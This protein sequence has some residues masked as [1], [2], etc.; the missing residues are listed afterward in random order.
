MKPG[1]NQNKR[2]LWQD[3]TPA[4]ATDKPNK[5]NRR[6]ITFVLPLLPK[7]RIPKKIKANL[8]TRRRRVIAVIIIAVLF[9][10]SIS[11]Y[12]VFEHNRAASSIPGSKITLPKGTPTYSTILPSGK[13]STELGGWTRISPPTSNAVYAYVDKIGTVQI[14][15]SEQPLPDSFKNNIEIQVQQLAEAQG[16]SEKITVGALTVHLGTY[17]KNTQRA[18]FSKNNLLILITS[19]GTITNNDWANYINSLN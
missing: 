17:D 15:V 1:G 11:G 5:K 9:V 13:S 16:A 18:I 8:N 4:V 6:E 2:V 14:S 10:A 3:V 7:I 12:L 19:T